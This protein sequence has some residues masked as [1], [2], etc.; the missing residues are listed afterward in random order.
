VRL[1]ACC[2]LRRRPFDGKRRLIVNNRLLGTAERMHRAAETVVSIDIGRVERKDFFEMC[3]SLVRPLQLEQCVAKTNVSFD[4]IWIESQGLFKINC[5]LL[6]AVE[7]SE[8][9]AQV[10]VSRA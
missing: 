3:H 8:S 7:R 5:R 4:I 1:R 2:G 6:M 10:L 9:I